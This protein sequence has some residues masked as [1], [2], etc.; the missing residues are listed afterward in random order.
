VR[1]SQVQVL[2][3]ATHR[4]LLNLAGP[5]LK[6]EFTPTSSCRACAGLGDGLQQAEHRDTGGQVGGGIDLMIRGLE[7]ECR[8]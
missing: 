6:A 3:D 8:R 4:V 2:D 5:A 7:A 1:I